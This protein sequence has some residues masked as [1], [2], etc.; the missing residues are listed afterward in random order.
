MYPFEK[1]FEYLHC[2]V[3]PCDSFEHIDSKCLVVSAEDAVRP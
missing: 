3:T 2:C 1:N